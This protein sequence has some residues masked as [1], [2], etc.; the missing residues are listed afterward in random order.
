MFSFIY[1][2]FAGFLVGYIAIGTLSYSYVD[3]HSNG[4]L[5]GFV[6]V[7]SM[8]PIALVV[9][10]FEYLNRK[11]VYNWMDKCDI[12]RPT[13][14]RV[15]ES[16][17]AREDKTVLWPDTIEHW[18]YGTTFILEECLEP[19]KKIFNL[20]DTPEDWEKALQYCIRT[21]RHGL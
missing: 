12:V 9:K 17:Q 8:W 11:Y 20:K 13:L 7:V 21:R 5:K 14:V 1:Q 18:T 15:L 10:L 3:P 6:S 4:S 2:Y 19:A 16:Y